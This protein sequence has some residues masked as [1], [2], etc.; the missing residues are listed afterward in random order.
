MRSKETGGPS[1]PA[2]TATDFDTNRHASPSDALSAVK[3]ELNR[4]EV[5]VDRLEIG[6][7]AN[8]DVTYRY[9]ELGA[10]D[11]DFGLLSLGE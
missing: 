10:D 7:E 9:R 8:G 3:T 2:Q 11:Y 1:S 6:F 4:A 5:Q